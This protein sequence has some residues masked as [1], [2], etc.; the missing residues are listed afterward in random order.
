LNLRFGWPAELK[1]L[2]GRRRPKLFAVTGKRV[3]ALAM[4]RREE[5]AE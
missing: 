4:R 2:A 1:A 3:V 5:E